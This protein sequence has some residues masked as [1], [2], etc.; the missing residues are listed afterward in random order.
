MSTRFLTFESS[1]HLSP[2]SLGVSSR[3]PKILCAKPRYEKF[4]LSG[5]F[6]SWWSWLNRARG[7]LSIYIQVSARTS[8]L[9]TPEAQTRSAS[10]RNPKRS[11]RPTYC[12]I[13]TCATTKLSPL[14]P[15][16]VSLGSPRLAERIIWNSLPSRWQSPVFLNLGDLRLQFRAVQGSGCT[17][18]S[19]RSF[20]TQAL[21]LNVKNTMGSAQEDI[22]ELVDKRLLEVD[23]IR[24]RARVHIPR[25]LLPRAVLCFMGPPARLR[26]N[27]CSGIDLSGLG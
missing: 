8:Q 25:I 14:D 1:Q 10:I 26:K 11:Q 17:R 16:P 12:G 21:V 3:G 4:K 13:A 9:Q 20:G 18:G 23:L 7:D 6:P 19:A 27:C 15:G 5:L 24:S 2:G 22:Y